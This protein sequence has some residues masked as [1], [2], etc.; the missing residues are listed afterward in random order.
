MPD[1]ARADV[2]RYIRQQTGVPTEGD[3]ARQLN[4]LTRYA[5][6]DAGVDIPADTL[7]WPPGQQISTLTATNTPGSGITR[8]VYLGKALAP[9]RSITVMLRIT[10]AHSG[11]TWA[12]VAIATGVP[13]IGGD[14]ELTLMG[15][16]ESVIGEWGSIGIKTQTIELTDSI[17]GDELWFLYGSVSTNM[18]QFRATVADDLQSGMFVEATVRPSTMAVNQAF[19]VCSATTPPA[20]LAF[21]GNQ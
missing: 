13:T 4:E 19:T 15:T 11:V 21:T 6:Q 17:P 5:R 18:A 1:S 20:W 12:E 2:E 9:Y 3:R 7:W 14:T 10:T 16:H 8:A